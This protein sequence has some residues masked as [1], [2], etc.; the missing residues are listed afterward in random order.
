MRGIGKGMSRLLRVRRRSNARPVR[1]RWVPDPVQEADLKAFRKVAKRHSPVLDKTLPPLTRSANRSLLWLTLAAALHFFGGRFGRRGALRGIFALVLTSGVTNLPVKNLWKRSRP[2]LDEVPEVRRLARLPT[3]TSF[4]S[5]H[6]ASAFAFAT[7]VA[8]ERPDVGVPLLGLAGAIAYSRVYVGVHYPS[9]VIAGALI[10]AG[11]AVAT[12]NLWPVTPG[13]PAQAR[14]AK[15][16]YDKRPGP[17][18][19]GLSIVV[20]PKAGAGFSGPP[21][22][23]LREALPAAEIIELDED[24]SLDEALEKAVAGGNAL[25]ICGG[26]GTVN[27]AAKVAHRAG[28]PLLVI[29]GGTLNHFA[30]DIGIRSVDDVVATVRE[31]DALGIDVGLIDGQP[32]LNTA[33]FGNYVDLVDARERLERQVGKWPAV[34]VALFRVLRK[35]QPAYVEINGEPVPVWMAFIGN[36]TYEPPGFTP[37]WR[38]RLDDKILDFRYV[39]AA[40]PFARLRLLW[41][42][43]TGTLSRS[44]VYRC[45]IEEG[46]IHIRSLTGQIRL[47]R[48]GETFKGNEEF[49]IE[50]S[51]EPLVVLVPPSSGD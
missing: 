26:D 38:K 18:G 5:G 14:P 6:A 30:R 10:G 29:P 41:A 40:E 46:P 37:S 23:E 21:V 25:G 28:V 2:S 1:A 9:D 22:D 27:A 43:A 39:S 31:G 34:V 3:S 4:P 35:A 20:N 13:E 12:R 51:P 17:D 44:K 16:S 32:F 33:S 45:R 49:T 8:L 48:D 15:V 42:V 50:K 47:A 7:G 36:C 19:A 24:L 11:V